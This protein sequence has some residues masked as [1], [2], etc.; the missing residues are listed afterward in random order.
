[1]RTIGHEAVRAAHPT[2]FLRRDLR[3]WADYFANKSEQ[4]VGVEGG[5]GFF[6]LQQARGHADGFGRLIPNFK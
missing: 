2:M 6:V 5:M 3:H 4:G 1:M